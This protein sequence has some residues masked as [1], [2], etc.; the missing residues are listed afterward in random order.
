MERGLQRSHRTVTVTACELQ[1]VLRRTSVLETS[2]EPRPTLRQI[3][4]LMKRDTAG[5]LSSSC[6]SWMERQEGRVRTARAWRP[7]VLSGVC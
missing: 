2:S 3:Y 7:R 5:I 1:E 4:A 6:G